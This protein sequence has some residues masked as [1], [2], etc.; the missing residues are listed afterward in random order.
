MMQRER[1]MVRFRAN[2]TLRARKTT[3]SLSA[4]LRSVAL[5]LVPVTGVGS[6]GYAGDVTPPTIYVVG[7]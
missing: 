7:Y 6:G 1:T 2:A 5:L 3:E 4:N